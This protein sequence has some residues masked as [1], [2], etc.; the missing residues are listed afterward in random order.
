MI[1]VDEGVRG[2]ELAAQFL[3][4]DQ[5]S[6][7]FEQRPQNLQGLFLELYLLSS[8]AQFPGVEIDLECTETNNSG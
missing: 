6:R 7:S 4:S 5:F 3:S 8:L 2:P 1:E